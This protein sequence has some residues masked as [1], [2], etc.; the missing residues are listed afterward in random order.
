MGQ[1]NCLVD[2]LLAQQWS[3]YFRDHPGQALN[4]WCYVATGLKVND[5][6]I[7]KLLHYICTSTSTCVWSLFQTFRLLYEEGFFVGAST[8]IN[9][10]G[11]VQVAKLLGPGHKIVT[12]L[13][14]TGHVSINI[15]TC[16]ELTTE[17]VIPNICWG[18]NLSGLFTGVPYKLSYPFHQVHSTFHKISNTMKP[19]YKDHLRDQQNIVLI[20]RWSLYAASIKWQVYIWMLVTCGLYKQAGGLCIQVVFI[21]RWSLEQ[22]CLWFIQVKPKGMFPIRSSLQLTMYPTTTCICS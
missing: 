20:H 2:L 3:L 19:L 6:R 8:G 17:V 1:S 12:C 22:V 13:C 9:V 7:E 10:E 11:A 5:C 21:Y 18:G 14:D 16:T 15:C 4:M